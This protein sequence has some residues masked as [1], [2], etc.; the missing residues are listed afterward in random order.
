MA[1]CSSHSAP[2]R[3]SAMSIDEKGDGDRKT[4]ARH[5]HRRRLL[6]TPRKFTYFEEEDELSDKEAQKKWHMR[7]VV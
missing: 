3:R 4:L 2:S 1:G 6:Y 7:F 5:A